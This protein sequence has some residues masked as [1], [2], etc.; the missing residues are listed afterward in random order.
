MDWIYDLEVF[1]NLFCVTFINPETQETKVF[2]VYKSR[3]T[4]EEL[5]KF[6]DNP[7]RLV[8][9]NN[10]TYDGVILY[11]IAYQLKSGP[12]DH[13]LS[14]LFNIS[15]KLISRD[16][17]D[18]SI[19]RYPKGIKYT[20][21]DLM[22]I[23]NFHSMGIGL[24]QVA[25]NLKWH[26][27]QDLPLPYDYTIQ[28]AD[29]VK[30]VL[31][32][33]LNDVLITQELYKAIQPKIKLREELG[34]LFKV[35]LSNSSDSNMANKLLERIYTQSTGQDIRD[36]KDLRTKRDTICIGE[37]M[38]KNISFL[39][40]TLKSLHAELQNTH[41]HAIGEFAYKKSVKV[42][43]TTYDL[44]VG[45][46][47]SR[48]NSAKFISDSDYL[49]R[50][51]D[52][53]SYYP[54]IMLLNDIKP[55]H[56]DTSFIDILRSITTERIEAKKTGRKVKAEGLKITIN[57]IFG[58][59]RSDT[60]WLED[61]KAFISVT[62]SGQL[63]LLMLIESLEL[64]GIPVISANTDGVIAKIH[65]EKLSSY[66]DICNTWS[67]L[68]GFDLE[69]TDYEVYV[70]SDVNNYLTKKANGETKAKG[71]YIQDVDLMRGYKHPITSKCLYEYFIN[72]KPVLDTLDDSRDILDYCIS[73]KTGGKFQLEHHTLGGIDKLQ[74]TN[75]FYIA[76]RG[77]ILIKRNMDTGKESG[78]YAKE[79]VRLLNNY[80]H[81]LPFDAYD[82]D[83]EFYR[84]EAQS[85]IEEIEPSIIQASFGF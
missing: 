38:G 12:V 52:V 73:Q 43:N 79:Q 34:K 50:D 77:G 78:L 66:T 85:Y 30:T 65:R 11:A 20:Q 54:N 58:K 32:Y 8:G 24:K 10:L 83:M 70:R 67:Q 28:T 4:R 19:C 64:N 42:G 56:L 29:E 40:P 26:R 15:K 71:R 68:T 6:L 45:G 53:A 81:T 27:I 5:R 60:F 62:V 69:C 21:L 16:R 17:D 46:L 18:K 35:E 80:D 41:V 75:R 13:A 1:K 76:N 82:V 48:D 74:K 9:F 31:D 44:G 2:G 63:Y 7:Y 25:I 3:D 49:Y 33:N 22:Q 23:M 84:K 14:Q 39:T 47:H 57:S 51:A 61:P 72:Q 36:I 37:C 59:L 55:D